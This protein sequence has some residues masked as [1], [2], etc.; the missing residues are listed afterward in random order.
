M[1]FILLIP[2]L[3][4]ATPIL[5]D[6][7]R[8]SLDSWGLWTGVAQTLGAIDPV[9]RESSSCGPFLLPPL[10]CM[11]P[12]SS[13][14]VKPHPGSWGD[15][16]GWQVLARKMQRGRRG[17]ESKEIM[18]KPSALSA[19]AKHLAG[20]ESEW[21]RNAGSWASRWQSGICVLERRVTEG[22]GD[23]GFSG[24]IPLACRL[25]GRLRRKEGR[26]RPCLEQSPGKKPKGKDGAMSPDQVWRWQA[27]R[28]GHLKG[29]CYSSWGI[30]AGLNQDGG[31]RAEEGE[32]LRRRKW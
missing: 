27:W 25:W 5:H 7:N 26:D 24:N 23:M 3:P 14:C 16:S 4:T 8:I 22:M 19:D 29:C 21:R 32:E 2:L 17:W 1:L 13:L 28:Q 11:F 30:H 10:P 31:D 20:L 18:E 9:G 12:K 15:T 6:Q